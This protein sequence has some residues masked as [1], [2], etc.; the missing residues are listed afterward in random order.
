[1]WS[2]VQP[3]GAR[4]CITMRITYS[5][6]SNDT[7]P[8]DGASIYDTY[9]R[10]SEALSIGYR[11][12]GVDTVSGPGTPAGWEWRKTGPNTPVLSHPAGMN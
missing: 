2:I 1:M 12:L 4:F 7:V 8:F 11:R 9:R 3:V 5:V 10:I 6:V